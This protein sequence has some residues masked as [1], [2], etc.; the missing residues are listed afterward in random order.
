MGGTDLY[1]FA[2]RSMFLVAIAFTYCLIKTHNHY[3]QFK[4]KHET[5]A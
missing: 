4:F 5:I 3:E 1:H 2:S